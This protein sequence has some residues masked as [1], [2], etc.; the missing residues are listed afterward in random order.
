ME[1]RAS[2]PGTRT[3]PVHR[4]GASALLSDQQSACGSS[5]ATFSSVMSVSAISPVVSK[6]TGAPSP[7]A[8]APATF[9]CAGTITVPAAT[10]SFFT[11]LNVSGT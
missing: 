5:A 10:G 3:R 4:P 9:V 1:R 7:G 8:G 11:R 2:G 6:T